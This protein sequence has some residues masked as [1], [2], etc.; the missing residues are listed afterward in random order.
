MKKEN[1]KRIKVMNVYLTEEE[2]NQIIESSNY[3]GLTIST[4]AR[5]VCLGYRV[6]SRNDQQTRT[7]MRKVNAEVIL[8]KKSSAFQ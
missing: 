6:Q 1:R 8:P 5:N 4:F 2:Y 3:T 7:D